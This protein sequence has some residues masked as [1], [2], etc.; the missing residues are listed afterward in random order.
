MVKNYAQ[1]DFGDSFRDAKVTDLINKERCRCRSPSGY[2]E[3]ADRV[4]GV[5][6]A[7]RS[8]RLR[9]TAATSTWTSSTIIVGYAI[10]AFC[11]A[12]PLIVVF[13]GGSHLDWF[14]CAGLP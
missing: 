3:H 5:D 8:P 4:P 11:S 7:A 2:G 6:P 10:L 12:I 13:A 1:L 14:H 9:D